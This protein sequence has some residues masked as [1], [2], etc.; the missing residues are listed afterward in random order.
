M[1][2]R[3]AVG[4]LDDG[5]PDAVALVWPVGAAFDDGAQAWGIA[6]G[7]PHDHD[8]MRVQRGERHR[9]QLGVA[10]GFEHLPHRDREPRALDGGAQNG[11]RP[12]VEG[13]GL[14]DLQRSR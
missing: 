14:V 12:V 11:V 6:V 5:L 13:R 1:T 8:V 4:V 9:T 2:H 10:H 3:A 7:P